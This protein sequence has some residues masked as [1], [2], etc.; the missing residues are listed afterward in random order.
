MSTAAG[1]AAVSGYDANRSGK[2]L[3]RWRNDVAH[4]KFGQAKKVE[5]REPITFDVADEADIACREHVN[6]KLLIELISQVESGSVGE[7]TKGILRVFNVCVRTDD[8]DEP[9]KWTGKPYS[10]D[11]PLANHTQL[12]LD[13][14]GERNDDIRAQNDEIREANDDLGPDEEPQPLEKYVSL[15]I[16]PTSSLG[17]LN[18]VLDDPDTRIE[19]EELAEIVGW[20]VEQFTGRPTKSAGGSSRGSSGTNR[21]SRR[22]RRSPAL[23][24]VG[25]TQDGS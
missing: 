8:G 25:G 3:T 2:C 16:D 19:V 24:S 20:I 15:G 13:A 21:G 1:W 18:K 9:D 12:E 22:A 4:R 6:G 17:R 11:K 5:E 10:P 23:T 7:Q 14:V